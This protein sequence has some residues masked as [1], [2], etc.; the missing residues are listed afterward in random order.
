MDELIELSSLH[1]LELSSNRLKAVACASLGALEELWLNDNPI[2]DVSAV[3]QV[4]RLTRLK[5]LYLAGC[6]LSKLG[7]YRA[8]VLG[9]APDSLAQLDADMLPLPQERLQTADWT[10]SAHEM[11][12]RNAA[13]AE[14]DPADGHP[15]A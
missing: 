6:P 9:V 1:T 5:T 4:G 8:D 12:L 11:Q 2:A 10:R 3:A 14:S 15:H 13:E 7:T